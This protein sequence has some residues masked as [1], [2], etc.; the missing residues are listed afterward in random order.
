[1]LLSKKNS[2]TNRNV[3]LSYHF[4]IRVRFVYARKCISSSS[5]PEWILALRRLFRGPKYGHSN[6]SVENGD[7]DED[8]RKMTVHLTELNTKQVRSEIL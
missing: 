1:M 4:K 7:G 5:D 8:R 3:H 2:Q 6:S